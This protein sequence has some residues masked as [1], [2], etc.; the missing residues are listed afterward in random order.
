MPMKLLIITN[1]YPNAAEP[2]RGLFNRQQVAEL[3]KRCSVTVVAPVPWMPGPLRRLTSHAPAA[4]I[5]SRERIDGIEVHHP[6]HLVIPWLTR[7]FNWLLLWWGLRPT[8]QRLH[9]QHR[10]DRMLATWAY[11]DVV[12]AS[13]LAAALGI[14]LVAKLHGS[15]INELAGGPWRRRLI[16]AALRSAARVIAVSSS[17]KAKTEALGVPA[18]RIE[19]I[20][21]GVDADVFAPRDRA[22]C[23]RRLGLP[24]DEPFVLFIGNLVP[25]KGLDDLLEAMWRCRAQEAAKPFR[26]VLIG[27]GPLRAE[28]QRRADSVGLRGRVVLAGAKP[29]EEIPVWLGACDALCLPSINE[30]CPNVVIEALAS[31]R[32]VIGTRTGGI[33]DLVRDG[34]TGVLV[35]VRDPDALA[36]GL[37][38]A[39]RTPWD[40]ERIHRSASGRGW[41]ANADDLF[42]VLQTAGTELTVLHVLRYSIPNMSGYT[43]RSQAL[44]EGQRAFGVRPVVVTSTRHEAATDRETLNGVPYYRCRQSANP[45]GR[46]PV[47]G[48]LAAMAQLRR[49]IISIGRAEGADVIHAHSPAM[50]G[51]PGLLAARRLRRPFIYEV[52]A[53]WEDAAVDQDKT[54]EG[55]LKYRLSRLLE[56]FVLRRADRIVVICDGLKQELVRRGLPA[57]KI[58]ITPNGVDTAQF[59]PL[60]GKDQGILDRYALGGSKVIGFIGSFFQFE[61]LESLLRAVPLMLRRDPQIKVLI[62][63]TGEQEA[64]LRALAQAAHLNGSVIFTGR[65]PHHEVPAYYSVMDALVYP[66]LSRRITELVTP[67]KPLEA[68]AFGRPVVASDVGGL[69]ELVSHGKT[70][71]LFKAED[72]EALAATC[73]QAVTDRAL[74]ATLARQGRAYVEQEREWRAICRRAADL[75]RTMGVSR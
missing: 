16:A 22:E 43:V 35:P 47:V 23:R 9:R 54:T 21:N 31:G 32:P 45:L 18:H 12:A 75:Y 57:E 50:C 13:R 46:V 17:L 6:R 8:V 5:P 14:P 69:R 49:R 62:V 33:P 15:D 7:P 10:F 61:G 34:D 53:L 4:A 11:P 56:T 52:R 41:G 73:V 42:R 27:D 24:V 55:S 44:I 36:S 25:V 68:M 3:A 58:A 20:P 51:L 30:G 71:L 67:L 60:A 19:V 72:L 39:L 48:E 38:K 2:R 29:H 37:L 1:L 28:I 40:A 65:V 70:G 74:A 64:A 66:R 59:Q 63:G 26:L